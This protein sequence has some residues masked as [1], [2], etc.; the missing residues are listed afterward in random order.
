MIRD[1]KET[2][3]AA[4]SHDEVAALVREYS[5]WKASAKDMIVAI[6]MIDM[7]RLMPPSVRAV[8]ARYLSSNELFCRECGETSCVHGYP[9]D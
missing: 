6:D 2:D 7:I 3:L 8:V 1:M 4:A 5:D 9:D